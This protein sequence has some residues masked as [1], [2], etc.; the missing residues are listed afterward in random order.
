[1]QRWV[2]VIWLALSLLWQYN[3]KAQAGFSPTGLLWK[4]SQRQNCLTPSLSGRVLHCPSHCVFFG[5]FSLQESQS[6]F[7]RWI[8]VQICKFG[9]RSISHFQGSP[10]SFISPHPSLSGWVQ[11]CLKGV[12]FLQCSLFHSCSKCDFKAWLKT[13]LYN[14]P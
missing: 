6:V 8:S 13:A 3:G 1:M 7:S 11:I 4:A 12:I 10:V 5:P 14:S 2:S 9:G